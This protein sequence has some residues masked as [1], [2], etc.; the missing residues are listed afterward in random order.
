MLLYNCLPGVCEQARAGL[1]APGTVGVSGLLRPTAPP[2]RGCSSEV[3]HQVKEA[4]PRVTGTCRDPVGAASQPPP[5]PRGGTAVSSHSVTMLPE[6]MRP[7]NRPGP[8][9]EKR[10]GQGGADFHFSFCLPL[11][12]QP[13]HIPPQLRWHRGH[14][15]TAVLPL[16][17]QSPD[18]RASS[19][20][21]KS[22]GSHS[23]KSLLP[24]GNEGGSSSHPAPRSTWKAPKPR[25]AS[26]TLCGPSLSLGKIYLQTSSFFLV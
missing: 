13:N 21:L 9:L 3:N 15:V 7:Q 1:A 5:E 4:R 23:W 18:W 8:I 16:H 26:P 10:R 24:L 17:A 20:G 14:Q 6:S 19:Y 22:T 25:A 12:R 11:A 2:S